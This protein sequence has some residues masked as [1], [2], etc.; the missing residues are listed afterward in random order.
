MKSMRGL[1]MVAVGPYRFFTVSLLSVRGHC[2]PLRA[3][4]RSPLVWPKKRVG[5]NMSD[6]TRRRFLVYGLGAGAGVV[7]L[8]RAEARGSV[9]SALSPLAAAQASPALTKFTEQLPIPGAMDLTGGGSASLALAPGSQ[10]FHAQLGAAATF[11]YGGASY[12]GPTL[13]VKQG[14][15]VSIKFSN[16]LG[17][18]PL[19]GS[20]DTTLGGAVA[21]DKTTPRA[22]A[23]V[24]GGLTPPSSTATRRTPTCRGARR[25][26][27]T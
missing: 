16:N 6:V 2:R 17:A 18:H 22:S 5:F 19:A 24:H 23:H 4:V 12:L 20:I 3:V 14:V 7:V 15:P 27:T 13:L 11:G 10:T 25:P 21:A 9:I 1:Y 26:T 8:G